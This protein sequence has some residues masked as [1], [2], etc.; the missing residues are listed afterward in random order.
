MT[1]LLI[2]WV[3]RATVLAATVWLVLRCLR[4]RSPRLE[5]S[6]WLLV[7]AASW[8]MPML[9]ELR[10][11]PAVTA[12]QLSWLS[13]VDLVAASSAPAGIDWRTA[14]LWGLASI[15]IVLGLRHSLGV[16]RWRRIQQSATPVA[17]SS[18][19]GLDIRATDAVSSPATVFSTILVPLDF[20]TWS[21]PIQR[22]VVA[23]ESAHVANKDFYVQWLAQLHRCVFWFSPLSWW[24]ANRLALLSEHISDDA[25]LHETRERAAY[26]EVLLGFA[27]RRGVGNEQLVSMAR[28]RTLG[29]RI[30]RILSGTTPTA[31]TRRRM[32]MFLAALV[33]LVGIVAGL[34]TVTARSKEPLAV[35]DDGRTVLPKRNPATRLSQPVYP[36]ASQRLGEHGTVVLNLFVLEDG[37]VADARIH[38]SSGYPDL[39][40][41]ALYETYRWRLD[42]GT[43]DGTPA[44]MWGRIA[45]TFKLTE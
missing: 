17:S 15:A 14:L 44:R 29:S 3:A 25:A 37:S 5:R 35:A 20:E 1:A 34:Q 12:Q 38:E 18:F 30:D 41:A 27:A 11:V 43:V 8:T 9:M 21:P 2:E 24:L 7:L 40:Y 42:P 39:D 23:H 16:L 28:A 4:I 26:A 6:A 36:P 13:Q 45:V 32:W 31:I 22:A 33:P 19:A 10:I